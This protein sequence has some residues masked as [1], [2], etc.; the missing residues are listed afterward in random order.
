M[1][2]TPVFVLKSAGWK[3]KIVGSFSANK[4]LRLD[5]EIDTMS[6]T[7]RYNADDM[8]FTVTIDPVVPDTIPK[9]LALFFKQVKKQG[10]GLWWVWSVTALVLAVL[11]GFA[12]ITGSIAVA[13]EW[14]GTIFSTVVGGVA[15]TAVVPWLSQK[16]RKTEDSSCKIKETTEDKVDK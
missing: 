10:E 8:T 15:S 11:M 16:M 5:G 14:F 13:T 9:T 2:S 1:K 7:P 6:V 3:G 4:E 12:W